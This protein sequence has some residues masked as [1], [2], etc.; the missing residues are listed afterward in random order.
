MEK[1]TNLKHKI[2]RTIRRV[3]S[4]NNNFKNIKAFE[5]FL[6]LKYIIKY[7]LQFLILFVPNLIYTKAKTSYFKHK[8]IYHCIF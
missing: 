3:A 8:K 1:H 5:T 2:N 4:C 6:L 7:L